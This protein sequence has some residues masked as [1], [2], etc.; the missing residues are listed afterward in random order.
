MLYSVHSQNRCNSAPYCITVK[1]L[2]K[3][4]VNV[5]GAFSHKFR[6]I[7]TMPVKE[8]VVKPILINAELSQLLLVGL[9]TALQFS[10]WGLYVHRHE[11]FGP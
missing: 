5:K 10:L 4:S 1:T 7:P 3:I 8:F 6:K 11:I 2:P 9:V